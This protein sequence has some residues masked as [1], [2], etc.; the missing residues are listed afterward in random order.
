MKFSQAKT[1]I[2]VPIVRYAFGLSLILLVTSIIIWIYFILMGFMELGHFPKYGDA[3]FISNDGLDRK[4]LIFSLIAMFY[5]T[6]TIII[7]YLLNIILKLKSIKKKLFFISLGLILINFI[8]INSS[9]FE[10]ALD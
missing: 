5:G 4:A 9:A 1:K 2:I 8:I 3:E 7:C 10:W 6:L